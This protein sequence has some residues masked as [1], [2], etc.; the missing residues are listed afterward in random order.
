M[1]CPQLFNQPPFIPIFEDYDYFKGELIGI[2]GHRGVLGRILYERLLN[3]GVR[4]EAYPGDINNVASLGAWF[5]EYD[6]D[7]FFH[8]AAVIS[9]NKVNTNPLRA[10]DF[11][12]II[13]TTEFNAEERYHHGS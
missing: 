10:H 2:A 5:G 7:Y 13:T 12:Q 4:V 8:F 6:L 3:H 1:K 9:A 11:M